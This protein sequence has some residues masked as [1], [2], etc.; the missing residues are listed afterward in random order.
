MTTNF[1]NIE[2]GEAITAASLNA[3]FTGVKD[4]I[5]ALD[6]SSVQ[7]NGMHH[8][9]LPS[10]VTGT[11]T[12]TVGAA[13][14][15]YTNNYEGMSGT[16]VLA[17]G[18]RTGTGWAIV[19]DG[20]DELTTTFSSNVELT[21]DRGVLVLAN[22]HIW[23]IQDATGGVQSH[24]FYAVFKIQVRYAITGVWMDIDRSERFV[25]AERR[26]V[27]GGAQEGPKKDL[28]I[29]TFITSDDVGARTI[30]AVR[31]LVATSAAGVSSGIADVEVTLYQGNISAIGLYAGGS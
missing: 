31:L 22:I 1:S 9:H 14:H 13:L 29:R 19:H 24:L 25:A 16:T 30:D 20:T 27:T 18:V 23:D 15:V 17:S 8:A 10:M 5:N 4:E 3:K 26:T 6:A 28:A 12:Q 21:T 11:G 2:E 7:R